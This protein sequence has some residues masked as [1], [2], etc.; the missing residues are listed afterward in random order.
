M[1]IKDWMKQD[2][3]SVN[4]DSSVKEAKRL[5]E[6]CHTRTLPVLKKGKLVGVVT[7]RDLKRAAPSDAT[8]LSR[9]EIAYLQE[10]IAVKD[11]MAKD[12]ITL[13]PTDTVEQAAMLFLEKGISGAPVVDDK[14]RLLGTMTQD[15]LFKVLITLT[16]AWHRG[17]Q[18]GF[19]LDDRPGS[20]KEVADIIRDFDGRVI[21]ILSSMEKAPWKSRFV[22]I[23]IRPIDKNLLQPL[24]D[25]LRKVAT[26]LYVLDQTNGSELTLGS[27]AP[28]EPAGVD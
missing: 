8:S 25:E 19:L 24:L 5:M 12:P 11:V 6:V 21:S 13:A 16:G 15:E 14:G 27:G 9:H 22:Y 20:I 26:I 17:I 3:V 28:N 10:K 18:F 1:L 23:R 2:G 7:D 4:T